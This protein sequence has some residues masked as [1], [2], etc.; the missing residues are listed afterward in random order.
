MICDESL[1]E[2]ITLRWVWCG[3]PITARYDPSAARLARRLIRGWSNF[4]QMYLDRL[5]MSN[6][7]GGPSKTALVR[8]VD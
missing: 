8:L 7:P 2:P 3:K 6:R 1:S 5:F 4:P